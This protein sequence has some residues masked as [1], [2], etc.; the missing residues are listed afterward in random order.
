[1]SHL[2]RH[3]FRILRFQ[4]IHIRQRHIS[5]AICSE[6]GF[7]FAVDDWE[8]VEDIFSV[9]LLQA[10][11]DIAVH[12]SSPARSSVLLKYPAKVT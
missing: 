2:H 6:G 3:H 12:Q 4:R 11:V 8:G 1:M 5:G 10:A 7:I 9:L